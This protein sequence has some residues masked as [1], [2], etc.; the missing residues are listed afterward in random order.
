MAAG[1]DTHSLMWGDPRKNVRINSLLPRWAL[2]QPFDFQWGPRGTLIG[3]FERVGLIKSQ[4]LKE[5]GEDW[6]KHFDLHFFPLNSRAETIPKHILFCPAPSRDETEAINEWT[7]VSDFVESKARQEMGIRETLPLPLLAQDCWGKHRFDDFLIDLIPLAERLHFKRAYIGPIWENDSTASDWQSRFNHCCTHAFLVTEKLGGIAG[8]RRLC[9]AAHA[10]RLQLCAW[11]G[12]YLGINSPLLQQHPEWAAKREDRHTPYHSGYPDTLVACDLNSG[13][14]D[15]LKD[16]LREVR[17]GAGLDML[18]QDSYA[19]LGFWVL[20]YAGAELVPNA[21][22]QVHLQAE[23]Q[24]MGYEV[25][26]EAVASFGLSGV[27][28][29]DDAYFFG[30]EAL[31]YKVCFGLPLLLSTDGR[32]R[33]TFAEYAHQGKLTPLGYFKFAANKAPLCIGLPSDPQSHS[34]HYAERIRSFRDAF[35]SDFVA[36]NRAYNA[37]VPLMEQRLLLPDDRGVLWRRGG[38]SADESRNKGVSGGILFAY[39]EFSQPAAKGSVVRDVTTG[40]EQAV[41]GKVF[42]TQPGHV[43]GVEGES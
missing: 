42:T 14:F 34:D 20:N 11:Y 16:R 24:K 33:E 32:Q 41:V 26:V 4:I 17:D 9:D 21:L 29:F 10:N 25:G 28:M 39:K 22:A 40:E 6:L 36:V 19:N 5:R 38:G 18:F 35:T 43:Y 12:C 3:F 27:G 37:V 30:R 23:M 1:S 13:F 8:L 15:Y 2:L 31:S 7:G